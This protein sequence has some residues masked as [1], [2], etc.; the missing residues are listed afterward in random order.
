MIKRLRTLSA[1]PE[2][3]GLISSMHDRQLTAAYVQ[4]QRIWCPLLACVG[5]AHTHTHTHK[6]QCSFFKDLF[7]YLSTHCSCTDG[8][9]PSS[10]CWELNLEP[11]LAAFNPA[12][13]IWPCSLRLKDLFIIIYKYTVAVFRHTRRGRQI[14]LQMIVSHHVGFE[15]RTF[16]RAVSALTHWAISPAQEHCSLSQL[17]KTISATLVL[18]KLQ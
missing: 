4:L 1:F 14:S 13:S 2:D 5:T 3:L 16:I 7:M 6:E 9:E 8:C 11:L 15:H 10:G 17:W 12:H 18:S